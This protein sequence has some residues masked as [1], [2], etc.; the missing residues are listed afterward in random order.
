MAG[1][2]DNLL[3]YYQR[4]MAYLRQ[5]GGLFAE[6]HPKIA[7][8]LD[9]GQGESTDPHVE[10]L[11][12]SFAFLA[13]TLQRD[14]DAEFPRISQTL[15]S[16]L[17]PQFVHI[18]PSCSI[19]QFQV[20]LKKSVPTTGYTIPKHTSLF[21]RTAEEATCQFQTGYDVDLWPIKIENISLVPIEEYNLSTFFTDQ[22]QAIKIKLTPLQG[23][24]K[25][26]GNLSQLRFFI[27]G[28]SA[29]QHILYEA[30][31]TSSE[32]VGIATESSKNVKIYPSSL[33]TVGLSQKDILLPHLLSSHP[34]YALLLEYFS[35]PDKFF[36]F[37][38]LGIQDSGADKELSIFV[39]VANSEALSWVDFSQDIFLLGCT[40]I[41]NSFK[42]ISEPFRL[43]GLS[44]EYRLV[45]DQRREMITEI[46]AVAAVYATSSNMPDPI[47]LSPYFEFMH[48]EEQED[49]KFF[50]VAR[51]IPTVRPG[52]PGTDT[53]LSFVDF[54]FNPSVPS[55]DTIYAHILCTNRDLAAQIPAGT[56]LEMEN[57][58]PSSSIICL[59]TPTSPLYPP[60]EGGMLWS[61]ISQLCLNR[62]SLSNE[63][64]SL[65]ALKSILRLYAGLGTPQT[66]NEIESITNINCSYT[67]QRLGK[68]AWRNFARGT[69]I[70]LT[71]DEKYYGGT[72]PFLF[73]M[74][75][76][77]FF[78]LYTSINS[79]TQLTIHKTSKPGIWKKWSPLAGETWLI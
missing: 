78:S 13:G 19:A 17:Y 16:I 65:D 14:M 61:L 74:V 22:P 18:V 34:A 1:E 60:Q 72:P 40:P 44:T 29:L 9:I 45:P 4:E 26:L 58:T 21:A 63:D 35:F 2:Q 37:D 68:E 11:L 23:S 59:N 64:Y 8:R 47:A 51:R 53:N 12:E 7:K 50:W 71:F 10:R 32:N 48:Q 43:D 54:N 67:V 30:I 56:I 15:L 66:A 25:D 36:F 75:L 76:N 5:M 42:K 69:S 79:F 3:T 46:N 31:F 24:F 62:I 33:K 49:Q 55:V 20:D 77:Y 70:D 28:G 73:A 41:V 52:M 38:V 57:D 39:P 6:R 27:N